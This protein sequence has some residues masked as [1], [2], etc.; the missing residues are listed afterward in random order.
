MSDYDALS[1]S[2]AG[3][4]LEYK[5]KANVPFIFHAKMAGHRRTNVL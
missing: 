1:L 4:V 2:L 5:N 3:I